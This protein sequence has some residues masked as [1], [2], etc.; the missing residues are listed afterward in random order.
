MEAVALDKSFQ[1]YKKIVRD[2]GLGTDLFDYILGFEATQKFKKIE[3]IAIQTGLPEGLVDLKL[4]EV[5]VEV[6]EY[7]EFI[8]KSCAL[9]HPNNS[10]LSSI[11]FMTQSVGT[12]YQSEFQ[13][14]SRVL[15]EWLAN[16]PYKGKL[17]FLPYRDSCPSTPE[18]QLSLC[19][20][21]AIGK[22]AQSRLDDWSN[23]HHHWASERNQAFVYLFGYFFL[24]PIFLLLL[25][26]L[27][28]CI[29]SIYTFVFAGFKPDQSPQSIHTEKRAE[30][31]PS[32]D[33]LSQGLYPG[34]AEN[35]SKSSS[36]TESDPRTIVTEIPLM[37]DK[38]GN[39]QVGLG[40]N[41]AG[42]CENQ[43]P[44]S[45]A[46]I[47]ARNEEGQRFSWF[48]SRRKLGAATELIWRSIVLAVASFILAAVIDTAIVVV[49]GYRPSTGSRTFY[50]WLMLFAAAHPPYIAN[51]LRWPQKVTAFFAGMTTGLMC[52]YLLMG[53][54]LGPLITES[55]AAISISLL[56]SLFGPMVAVVTAFAVSKAVVRRLAK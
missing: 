13:R 10:S 8:K 49:T 28:S 56:A 2:S 48:P 1:E 3:R 55:I 26:P 23:A 37:P 33:S 38:V 50:L 31:L 42:G 12:D 24:V 19:E 35:G 54:V 20:V 7:S 39:G 41:S 22:E 16:H 34:L 17:G 11:C 21:K 44:P 46:A 45:A 36:S 4:N 27:Y 18:K 47:S 40:T 53:P 9:R 15:A 25:V 52:Q 32:A 5:E 51:T 14:R 6:E 29:A 43:L 30:A